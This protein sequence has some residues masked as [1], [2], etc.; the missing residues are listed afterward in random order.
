MAPMGGDSQQGEMRKPLRFSDQKS[1]P[2][3]HGSTP[4]TELSFVS[5]V[6][7]GDWLLAVGC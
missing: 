7:M 3:A 4:C 5:M 2:L 6:S 1:A